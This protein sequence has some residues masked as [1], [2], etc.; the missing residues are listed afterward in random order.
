MAPEIVKEVSKRFCINFI[1]L[2]YFIFIFIFFIFFI[3]LPVWDLISGCHCK[4]SRIFFLI[5]SF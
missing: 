2:F 3:I 4:V 1:F 5:I